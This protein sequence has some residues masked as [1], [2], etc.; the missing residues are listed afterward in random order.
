MKREYKND[1][2]EEGS[3]KGK[4]ATSWCE[5]KKKLDECGHKLKLTPY[6]NT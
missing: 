1:Q 5:L 6:T 4:G 2:G 3:R